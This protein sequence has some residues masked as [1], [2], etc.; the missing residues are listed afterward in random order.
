MKLFESVGGEA[1]EIDKSGLSTVWFQPRKIDNRINFCHE[2]I[3]GEVQW[4]ERRNCT[5]S[6]WTYRRHLIKYQGK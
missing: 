4:E 6:L 1:E 2:A 3:P 5:M